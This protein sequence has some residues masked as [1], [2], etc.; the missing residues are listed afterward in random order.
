MKNIAL[1]CVAAAFMLCATYA[2]AWQ[3]AV[4]K[5]TM[6]RHLTVAATSS[7]RFQAAN[8]QDT[9]R[10]GASV[11][12]AR[13]GFG[14][15]TFND[16]SVLRINE[17]TEMVVREVSR[18]RRMQLQRGALWLRVAQGAGTSIQTP[19]ATATVRGTELAIDDLGNMEVIEG[20]VWYEAG[21][22]GILV[23]GGERA[24]IGPDGKP[25]KESNQELDE[26]KKNKWWLGFFEIA[27]ELVLPTSQQLVAMTTAT[28]VIAGGGFDTGTNVPEPGTMIAMGTGLALA[29][30]R[31]R[32][33]RG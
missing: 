15:I 32:L 21:G 25:A 16:D 13:R 14:E 18:L 22:E 3:G 33:K 17:R 1:L 6:A 11:R 7:G 10:D 20:E 19:V 8:I 29:V 2:R 28:L 5:L 24:S 31:R 4:G 26:S 9:I 23:F 12:T 27:D 30:G